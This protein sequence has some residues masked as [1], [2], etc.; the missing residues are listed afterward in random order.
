VEA[1]KL[2][3]NLFERIF[4][5]EGDGKKL[6][7]KQLHYVGWPDHGV[8]SGASILDFEHTLG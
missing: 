5:V 7:V 2:S 8:P 1:N 6:R 3:E 4:E